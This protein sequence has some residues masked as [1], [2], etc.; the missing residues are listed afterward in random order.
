M[1]AAAAASST[2]RVEVLGDVRVLL[3]GHPLPLPPSRRT[4]ALLGYLAVTRRPQLRQRLCD[5]LW[6]GPDDPRAA[7]RWSLAKLRPLLDHGRRRLV[8]EGDGVGLELDP[9]ELDLGTV[10]AAVEGGAQAAGPCALRRAA[11]AFRGELLEGLEVPGCYR[12]EEWAAAE[13]AAARRLR[14]SILDALVAGCEADPEEALVHAR[15]RVAVDALSES[16]HAAVIRLLGRLGRVREGLEQYDACRQILARALGVRPSAELERARLGL[17]L[18]RASPPPAGSG[19][20]P[21]PAQAPPRA[22]LGPA[23]VGRARERAALDRIVAEVKD[24]RYRVLLVVGEPGVG[25]SRVLEELAA[26]FRAVGGRVARGRAYEAEMLRPYAAWLDALR[27]APLSTLDGIQRTELAPLLPELGPPGPATDENRLFE[28]VARAL[29]SL[30][31]DRPLAL[32][33]DDAQWLDQRSTA[34]LHYVARSLRERPVL[35][36][37]AARAAELADNPAAL[38][39]ARTLSRG[40]EVTRIE[41]GPLGPEEIAALATSVDPSLDGARIYQES[42][43]NPLLALELARALRAGADAS[44]SLDALLAERLESLAGRAREVLPWAAALGRS[45]RVD[46]LAR[47]TGIPAPDLLSAVE[48]L[49]RRGVLRPAGEGAYDFA[50]DLVRRAA[51]RTLS[52]PRRQLLHREVAR[53]LAPL[54]DPDGA[55][56]GEIAHHAALGEDAELAAQASVGA[57]ARATRLFACAE[58]RG[59][60]ERG[61]G[62]AQR[63]PDQPRISVS[64]ALLRVAVDASRTLGGDPSL[65]PRIQVLIDEARAHGLAAEEAAG[66]GILAHAHFANLD[67]EH[68]AELLG[69]DALRR[70]EPDGAAVA[71]GEV[72]GCLA[73]LERDIPRARLLVEESRRFGSVPP[74]AAVYLA[75]ATGI[76]QALDGDLEEAARSFERGLGLVAE[77]APWEECVLLA[78][79]A[80]AHLALGRPRRALD[81]A[82][83]MEVASPR[84][85]VTG[86]LLVPRALRAVARRLQGDPIDDDALLQALDPLEVDAKARFAGLT[87]ALA[88]G[89]LAAGRIEPSRSLLERGC[90][91]AERVARPSLVVMGHAL[92]ARAEHAR[93]DERAARAHLDAA[94]L[95]LEPSVPMARAV[96]VLEEVAGA[97]GESPTPLPRQSV[98]MDEVHGAR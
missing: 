4:R 55:L 89:E 92:L 54:P 7:L 72:A 34:L 81:C 59:L 51:Y 97:L 91:A 82:D 63:L 76:I 23:F 60:V 41:L 75:A 42:E 46:R 20:P 61:L 5:L 80:L 77:G 14:L 96:R 87:C 64:L 15:A 88:E 67:A 79:L 84:L 62:F 90:A 33:L 19:P 28:A 45:F 58:A 74:R 37:C 13:R 98:A 95:A 32:V 48:E 6:D 30:A 85:G 25:K 35:L 10:Q 94:R 36:A 65:V 78:H 47:V 50:H 1:P 52:G 16:G 44:G 69:H 56:A 70:I 12:F 39:V 38:R 71:M 9:G 22:A 11:A 27:D 53:A 66:Y 29:A 2:L 8:A 83:R 57:A 43:G 17:T 93:G 18:A 21:R 3:G 31:A 86:E 68:A 73:L 24:G 26:R 49:E 40:E